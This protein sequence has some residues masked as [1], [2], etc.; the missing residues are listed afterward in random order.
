MEV[1]APNCV[2]LPLHLEWESSDTR[3]K[4]EQILHWTSSMP[5]RRIL[6]SNEEREESMYVCSKCRKSII[7]IKMLLVCAAFASRT[8]WHLAARNTLS[9]SRTNGKA[10]YLV[11]L[12]SYFTTIHE[13]ER[14]GRG[15]G[16]LAAIILSRDMG[17]VSE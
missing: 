1:R 5:R 3:T 15:P 6:A 4:R 7:I 13:A 12:L 16:C 8:W 14:S 11:C 10:S 9:S 2:C 17:R